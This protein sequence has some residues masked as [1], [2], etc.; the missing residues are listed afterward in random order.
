MFSASV[1]LYKKYF[2]TQ[3]AHKLFTINY[4]G[5]EQMFC[6]CFMTTKK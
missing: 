2:I 5:Y 4:N 3:T 6:K 1:F